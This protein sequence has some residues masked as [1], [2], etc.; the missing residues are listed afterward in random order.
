MA[1]TDFQRTICR[2]LAEQR[3]ASGE[4]YVAGGV[5]LNEILATSRL[6]R[7]IDLFHDTD[8]ALEASWSADRRLLEE[9]GFEVRVLR[10]RPSFVEARVARD[11]EVV[12][13]EWVRDS[14]FRFFPLQ[15]H[16]DLGLTLHPFDLATNKTLALVGRIEVRDW[17]D[18][19]H[20]CER[21][22]PLG[23][24]A[25]AACGKDPGFGPKGILDVA[26]R[27]AR[28]SADEV[29][30]LSFVGPPPAPDDLARRWHA[31]LDT[32]REVVDILPLSHLGQC[33]LGREGRFFTG[34]AAAL[35]SAVNGDHLAFHQGR[36][37]G[38]WP[39]IKPA[40]AT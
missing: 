16:P 18:L 34:D 10:E 3:K 17:V 21:V 4:S 5:A 31:L 7:D 27:T 20:A 25:W 39:E 26:A 40:D 1:L 28:Y 30:A 19:I 14:A 2:L 32:A 22:Q 6:S 33:V 13:M 37:R 38:A 8:E 15:T 11:G 29:R 36:I 23:Y 24:L 9:H 12:L 35:R